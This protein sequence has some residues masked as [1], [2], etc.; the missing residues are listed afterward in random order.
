MN[1]NNQ[2]F[3]P[4]PHILRHLVKHDISVPGWIPYSLDR[5]LSLNELHIL[6]A[7]LDRFSISQLPI[8][9]ILSGVEIEQVSHFHFEVDRKRFVTRRVLLRMVLGSVLG[10]EPGELEFGSNLYGKPSLNRHRVVLYTLILLI[11]ITWHYL[12]YMQGVK[13]ELT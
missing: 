10:R 2:D 13:W 12:P 8:R 9:S 3:F 5:N 6:R 11:P 7:D 1:H 4:L